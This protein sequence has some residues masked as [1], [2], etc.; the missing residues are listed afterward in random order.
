MAER[1]ERDRPSARFRWLLHIDLDQFQVS[2]ER[3]RRTDLIDIAVIVGGDG[4]PSHGRQVV[5]CASYEARAAG[6]RA[7]LPMP[8]AKKKC[9]DAVF[10]PLD[11]DYYT[12]VSTRV[13]DV[14]R[15]QGYPVEVWGF[16]EAYLGIDGGGIDASAGGRPHERTEIVALAD[17]IRRAV[18]DATGLP[19]CLGVSDNKQRAKAAA[20]FAKAA[21]RS[22]DAAAEDRVFVLDDVNWAELMGPRP[23]RD[24]WSVGPKTAAKLADRGI[25]TVDR[26]QGVARD[27]LVEWFGPSQGNWLYVLC[28]GGGD[29]AIAVEPWIA[30]SHSR[31]RTYPEDLTDREQVRAAATELAR[32]VREQVMNEGRVPFR[33]GL[34]VRTSTFYTRTKMRKMA[35]PSTE[36]A[37]IGPVVDGLVDAFDLDRPVRLLAVRLELLDV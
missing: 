9:P 36:F 21:V 1:T 17:R 4:D 20:G 7:G 5:T 27:D 8:A 31:S 30:R 24:L 15:E 10:L 35:E 33:V 37:A 19:C 26:L 11:M 29:D 22:P 28:R 23:C 6:V 18:S 34:T 2:A 13:M 32:E 14:L 12:Q 25:D 3:L 16:D